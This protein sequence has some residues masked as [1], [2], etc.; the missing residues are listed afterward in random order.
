MI[1]GVT[2]KAI[3]ELFRTFDPDTLG[4]AIN[5]REFNKMAHTIF[6]LTL[7]TKKLTATS[8]NANKFLTFDYN[9]YKAD[10]NAT[11][12]LVLQARELRDDL[13]EAAAMLDK[14]T[15]KFNDELELFFERTGM[16]YKEFDR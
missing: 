15:D 10:G 12:A 9:T 6:E 3:I 5:D 13:N 14:Y 7:F 1:T 11:A 4:I 8:V 16:G 2:R